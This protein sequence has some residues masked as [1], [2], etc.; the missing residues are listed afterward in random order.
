MQRTYVQ[1]CC[2]LL[3]AA[4]PSLTL[5]LGLETLPDIDRYAE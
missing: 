3:H 4:I 5:V 2:M 1:G